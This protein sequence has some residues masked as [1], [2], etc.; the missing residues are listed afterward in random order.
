[1]RHRDQPAR[2]T[3]RYEDHSEDEDDRDECTKNVRTHGKR[4]GGDRDREAA[5]RHPARDDQRRERKERD[6]GTKRTR[7]DADSDVPESRV[8]ANGDRRY[9]SH[10]ESESDGLP[11]A[12]DAADDDV[13]DDHAQDELARARLQVYKAKALQRLGAGKRSAGIK[14][15]SQ[16]AP[17]RRADS[18]LSD[19]WMGDDLD[20]VP[21]EVAAAPALKVELGGHEVGGGNHG[22][23]KTRVVEP[24]ETPR[25]Q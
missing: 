9:S 25:G 20:A 18:D 6:Q 21:L 17:S 12:A 22:M 24:G 15:G 7:H 14:Q 3:E 16:A 5:P 8:P 1:M 11:H 13:A 23:A 19:R 4:A 2:A 10:S